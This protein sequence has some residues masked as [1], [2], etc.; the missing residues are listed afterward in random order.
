MKI[1]SALAAVFLALSG[2]LTHAGPVEELM[3]KD[4]VLKAK[5]EATGRK[6]RDSVKELLDNRSPLASVSYTA[7]GCDTSGMLSRT[8]AAVTNSYTPTEMVVTIQCGDGTSPEGFERE[9][10]LYCKTKQIRMTHPQG[11]TAPSTAEARSAY[12]RLCKQPW[13]FN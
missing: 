3:A 8:K 9:G 10:T 4:P 7:L 12:S 11:A 1:R 2:S 13:N 5:L 6:Y